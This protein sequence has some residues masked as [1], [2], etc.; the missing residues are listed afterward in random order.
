VETSEEGGASGAR[1]LAPGDR[2]VVATHNDGKLREITSLLAPFGLTL[3]PAR[4]LGLP[5]VEETGTTFV[6]NATLKA[7][8]A[9]RA[10]GLP[11]L[12]DDSGI[13][14]AALG[15][16]PGVHSARWAALPDGSR[17]FTVA[18]A[19]ARARLG[20]PDDKRAWFTCCLVLAWPDGVFESF[21]GRVDG[22]WVWPPRGS[23]GFGYDPMFVPDGERET[24]GEMDAARKH[25]MSHR[26]RAFGLLA[27][28]LAGS[29]D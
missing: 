22:Q 14:F 27:A 20:E 24:F 16:A 1:R 6:E 5:E 10:S 12:A 19:L 11:A 29:G 7:V 13:G 23:C 18:M 2:V 17:D 25:A 21:E 4:Q 9:A 3:V 15:G 8:A 26:A 28:R